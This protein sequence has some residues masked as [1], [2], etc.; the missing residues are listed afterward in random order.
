MVP[1]RFW[2]RHEQGRV[3]NPDGTTSVYCN[4]CGREIMRTVHPTIRTVSRCQL[5]ILKAQG[6]LNAED[7][8]LAQYMLPDAT[9]P[10][11]PIDIDD[12]IA[13]GVL[14]LYPEERMKRGEIVPQTGG[15]I[16]TIKSMFRT[17]GFQQQAPKAPEPSKTMASEKRTGIFGPNQSRKL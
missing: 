16:G 7:Y 2:I 11:V 6:V 9:K 3:R 15:V 17:L 5:C 13:A 4:K 12:S 1:N 8:V 14:L 10:P